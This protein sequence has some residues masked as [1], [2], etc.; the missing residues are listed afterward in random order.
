MGFHA[1]APTQPRCC[2]H[3]HS[4]LTLLSLV[5]AVAL[6]FVA[7][8]CLAGAKLYAPGVAMYVL[9]V[10]CMTLYAG[11]ERHSSGRA[12]GGV[13]RSWRVPWRQVI[14]AL[15][16]ATT[17]GGSL[18]L[19]WRNTGY[20]LQVVLWLAGM[21]FLVIC[22]WP[23]GYPWRRLGERLWANR[24]EIALLGAMTLAGL[25]LRA[26][27]LEHIPGG[28]HGDEGEWSDYA[29]R[30]L[31]GRIVPPFA[32]GWDQHP[33]LFS[34]LQAGS[35]ALFGRD[36][37]GVRMLSALT[38]ALTLP[39]VYLLVRRMLGRWAAWVATLLLTVSHW[40][41]HFSRLAMN[42][43]QVSLFA[44]LTLLFLYRGIRSRR[45]LDYC[46]SGLSLGVAFN[47]GNKAVFIPPIVLL[48]LAYMVITQRGYLR[49][50]YRNLIVL[51][52]AG[53][54]AF[55]PLGMF[56]VQRDWQTLLFSRTQNRSIWRN[57]ERTYT[58][59]GVDSKAEALLHQVEKTLLVFN[60]Y[61]DNAFY[62]F[63]REPVLD[64][65]TA[66]LYVLGLVYCL[67]R[68]RQPRYALLFFWY[69]VPVLGN[70]LSI[71][72]PQ[73]HRMVALIPAPFIIAAV[74]A[75]R[76]RAEVVQRVPMPAAR[77][78]RMVL[79]VPVV[80][81]LAAVCYLNIDAYFVRYATR[82]PWRNVTDVAR[83]IKSVG[84]DRQIYL[85]SDLPFGHGTIRFIAHGV[86]GVEARNVTEFVPVQED[87]SRDAVFIITPSHYHLLQAI[88]E[89]YPGG[90]LSEYSEFR[91]YE[92]SRLEIA[93]RLR[94][95][96]E[97]TSG[98]WGEYYPNPTWQGKPVWERADQFLALRD[99]HPPVEGPF[100]VRWEGTLRLD[101][102]G[103]YVFEFLV[104]G[105]LWFYLG[106][107]LVLHDGQVAG[108]RWVKSMVDLPAASRRVE[109][110]YRHVSGRRVIEWY[111][112]PPGGTRELVPQSAL[113]H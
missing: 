11:F 75:D 55:A 82:W 41:I 43:I 88:R 113:S 100:S 53:V 49:R 109:I 76:L 21:A 91:A 5:I 102:S 81:F 98:L 8:F 27:D 70:V 31:E 107:E 4:Q 26:Y 51:A 65:L 57:W 52:V 97:K 90:R 3:M 68:W 99:Y 40:H 34:Y 69:L 28:F 19:Q 9:A 62:S 103:E 60:Y 20:A 14:A 64:P 80:L 50:Q 104:N 66:P 111:W 44:A 47:F 37:G 58:A 16:V 30:I 67:L 54:V 46:L 61:A 71:D 18:L 32:I 108:E 17:I 38:G 77:G 48:F 93:Q 25:I 73:V 39:V 83:Y 23:R 95:A 96:R 87:L 59:Y 106:D 24:G 1:D 85:V 89:T 45:A 105:E 79:A 92:V 94:E 7:Q 78:R 33:T 72:P 36:V 63:T 110:R 29:L 86:R 42:D 15:L 112:T 13:A 6:A 101:R 74:V 12:P 35:M 22:C 56:Y 2:L 10:G 84:N